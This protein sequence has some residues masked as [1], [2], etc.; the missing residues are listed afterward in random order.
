MKL[1]PFTVKRNPEL[2]AFTKGGLR[3]ARDGA[4][5]DA[6]LIVNSAEPELP[7]PGAGLLTRT[8]AVPEVVM[9]AA[10]ICACN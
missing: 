5:L 2:P 7:P 1:L 9:S 8:A 3:D 6:A 4:G 10:V